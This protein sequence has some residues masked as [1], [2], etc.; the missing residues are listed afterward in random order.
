MIEVKLEEQ[1]ANT[2]HPVI[3]DTEYPNW[4]AKMAAALVERWGWSL[5]SPTVRTLLAA[6]SYDFRVRRS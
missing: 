4:E 6:R 2:L 1:F 5:V 3:H